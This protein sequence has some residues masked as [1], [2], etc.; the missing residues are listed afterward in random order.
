MQ[1]STN[2]Q[3]KNKEKNQLHQKVLLFTRQYHILNRK[4][5]LVPK[6]I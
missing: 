3:R 2:F 5:K 6:N 1:E 4:F